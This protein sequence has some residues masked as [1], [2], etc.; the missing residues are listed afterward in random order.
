MTVPMGAGTT[1]PL[2]PSPFA[3][4]MT[5]R[6]SHR[7]SIWLL[8]LAPTALSAQATR[9]PGDLAHKLDTT[10]ARF[11]TAHHVPGLAAAVIA[12]GQPAWSKGFGMADLENQVPATPRTLFRLASVSKPMTAI[13]ALELSERGKLHLDAPVQ[14]YCPA[15]PEK[16]WPITTREVLGHLAGIRHY[17]SDAPD[18]AETGNTRH[19]TDPIAGGLSMFA[20]DSLVA[21]PRTRFN[22]STHGYT[23]VG[24]VIQGASGEHYAD[25]MRQRV[26]VPAGMT[27]TVVDDR[28]AVIPHRTRFYHWDSAG[29]VIANADLLDPSYKLPGGGWLSSVDDMTRFEVAL[30]HDTLVRRATRTMAWTSQHTTDGRLTGYGMGWGIDTSGVVRRI[31]HTGGQQ[32][33]STVIM[34]A[35]DADAGV[36]ALANIDDVD[37][38]ALAKDMLTLVLDA[39]RHEP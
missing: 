35:P 16:P 25:Y 14:R 6:T 22:Y 15:F 34:L 9:I 31:G 21:A 11:M 32:G 13:G 17:R 27:H 33:T 39:Q 12:N 18:D 3:T 8:A 5:M 20:A 36:V 37:V 2:T 24:C 4:A 10:I 23:L 29:R 7:H 38:E 19:F 1:P 26:F 30:L 28:Y